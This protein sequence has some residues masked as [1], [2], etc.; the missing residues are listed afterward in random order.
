MAIRLES[1]LG[2]S[3]D[4]LGEARLPMSAPEPRGRFARVAKKFAFLRGLLLALFRR[5]KNQ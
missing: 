5:Y 4:R 2:G 1:A 3:A